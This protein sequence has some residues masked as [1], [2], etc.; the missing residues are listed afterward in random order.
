MQCVSNWPGTKVTLSFT[1]L[2]QL[3][4]V[5]M[6]RPLISLVLW[7]FPVALVAQAPGPPPYEIFAGYSWLSNSFNGVPGSRQGLNGEEGS[8]AFPGWHGLRVKV[9]VAHYSGTNLGAKQDAVFIMGGGQYEHNFHRERVF[10]Q[11]LFGDIGMNRYWGAGGQPGETASFVTKLG[12][13]VDTPVSRNF[14]FRVEGD[15]LNENLALIRSLNDPRPY[16]VPGLPQNFF[17]LTAG[18]VWLPHA[19]SPASERGQYKDPVESELTLEGIN[20]FGHIHIFANSWW[21]YLHLGGIEYD[22]HSWG[23]FIGARRD[24]VAEVLPVAILRQPN[25][26]NVYGISRSRTFESIY[27][28]GISP[29]GMRLIWLDK[30]PVKPYYTVKGGLLAFDKKATSQYAAYLNFSLE[31]SV[32]VQVRMTDRVDLRAGFEVF[33]FSDAF[34]VPS[35]PGLDSMTY[36]GGITMHLGKLGEQ[37]LSQ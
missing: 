18:L 13:G 8:V 12:G 23:R 20:S 22:R 32:G 7:L 10:G 34:I 27:G 17:G 1:L 25:G 4:K 2:Y 14:A 15:W 9:D 21:S 29:V 26:T 3:T 28:V 5:Y 24:Y 36:T 33:H 6:R 16:R 37:P 35:N 11:A 30:K 19:D 31:Q